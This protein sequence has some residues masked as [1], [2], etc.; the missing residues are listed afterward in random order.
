MGKLLLCAGLLVAAALVFLFGP[1]AA[2]ATNATEQ[3]A[4]TT[5][6]RGN[7][8]ESTVATGTVKPMVGAE[9]KVGSQISGVV[10][11]LKIRVGDKVSKGELL[12]TL[13]DRE[14]RLKIGSLKAERAGA[15]AE[16]KYAMSELARYESA[17]MSI[18]LIQ[19][20]NS[21][22]NLAVRDAA[23]GGIDA[24]LADAQLQLGHSRITAPISGTISSVSTYEGETVAASFAAPTFATI[25]DLSRLEIHAFVDEA[26]IGRVRVGQQVLLKIASFPSRELKGNVR[27]IYPKAE[28]TNNVV[29]Y[30]LIIDILD[31][32]DLEIRPEMTVHVNFILAARNGVL[33]VPRSAVINE[34]GQSFVVRQ[35]G[36]TFERKAV[37]TGMRTSKL[38]EVTAGLVEGD[39]VVTDALL[40]K[41]SQKDES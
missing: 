19:L 34:G 26:D 28:L 23:V 8:V 33:S 13:D 32:A 2:D 29:N 3:V 17:P 5:V 40:W 9:V 41:Q 30:V 20:E 27:A 22:R 12:A 1:G 11:E 6:V 38:V 16:K 18:P 36:S 35:T 39:S 31:G 7:L 21:R 10:A 14:L 15:I 24:R 37:K 25:I 4:A